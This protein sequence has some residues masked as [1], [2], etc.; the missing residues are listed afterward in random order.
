VGCEAVGVGDGEGAEGLFPA[1]HDLAF[2]EFAGCFAGSSGCSLFLGSGAC[3]FVF[4]VADR[5]PEEFDDGV[6]GGEVAAVLD[7][8]AE[9]VVQRLD[10]VCRV[11]DLADLWWERQERDE[12]L[13]ATRGRTC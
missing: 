5:Q 4:D 9:L 1:V 7:D 11:D 3:A 6:V 12:P 13:R 10:R 2:D 8:L